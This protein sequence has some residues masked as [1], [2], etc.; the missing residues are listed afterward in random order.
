ML[1][2]PPFEEDAALLEAVSDAD[3]E[4][5]LLLPERVV[6]VEFE[7]SEAIAKIPLAADSEEAEALAFD[8]DE[9][10]A[11]ETEALEAAADNDDS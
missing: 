7:A 4:V 1:L 9:T 5:E 3:V 2:A 11:A 6:V 10:E 8:A